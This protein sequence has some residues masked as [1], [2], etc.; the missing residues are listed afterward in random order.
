MKRNQRGSIKKILTCILTMTFVLSITINFAALAATKK[1]KI[2]DKKIEQMTGKKA[3]FVGDS[4][5][6]GVYYF[7]PFDNAQFVTK[8]G[9]NVINAQNEKKKIWSNGNST[10]SILEGIKAKKPKYIYIM[11]GANE[12]AW[13]N[14]KVADKYYNRFVKKIK[15]QCPKAQITILSVQ[16]ATTAYCASN[17]GF[18]NAKVRS[19]NA[20]LKKI[21]KKQKVKYISLYKYFADQNGNLKTELAGSDGLHWKVNGVQVFSQALKTELKK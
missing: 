9:L 8:I 5:M 20:S 13:L 3:C 12:L 2:T 21:A 16:P 19:Y 14:L 4:L 1:S 6:Q 17:K 15:K 10:M 18:T 7:T 11:L